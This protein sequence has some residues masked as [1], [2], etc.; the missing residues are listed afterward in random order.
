MSYIESRGVITVPPPTRR[1]SVEE[2]DA[3][4]RCCARPAVTEAW[5]PGELAAVLDMLGLDR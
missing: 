2:R 1:G 5:P 4:R 3:A